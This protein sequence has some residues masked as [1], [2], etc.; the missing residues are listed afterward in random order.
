MKLGRWFA[1]YCDNSNS[2]RQRNQKPN[3]AVLVV[4]ADLVDAVVALA[5]FFVVAVVV[6]VVV[7]VVDA[8]VDVDADA[9]SVDTVGGGLASVV[10]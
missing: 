6:V 1:S 5:E 3:L 4:A 9:A 7:V 2:R 10:E 8:V